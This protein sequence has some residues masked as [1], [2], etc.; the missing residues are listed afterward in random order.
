MKTFCIL[1]KG[2]TYE[3]PNRKLGSYEG[4]RYCSSRVGTSTLQFLSGNINSIVPERNN[5]QEA[6]ELEAPKKKSDCM[7]ILLGFM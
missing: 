3:V 7:S 6:P 5:H 4:T 1:F 2:A